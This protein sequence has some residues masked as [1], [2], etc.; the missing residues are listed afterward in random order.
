MKRFINS[1]MFIFCVLFAQA[2]VLE[3][4]EEMPQFPG[5]MRACMQF[6]ARNVKYPASAQEAGKQGKV[7]VSFVVNTDGTI[8]DTQVV[9]SISPDLDKEALRV[10][11]LMPKWQPGKQKGKPVRVKYTMPINFQLSN[12]G[13]KNVQ[14]YRNPEV[15]GGMPTINAFLESMIK[16]PEKAKASGKHG[17]VIVAFVVEEDGSISNIELLN[18][19]D[20]QL[21]K[22]AMR[23]V[24]LMPKWNPAIFEGKPVRSKT[25]IPVKFSLPSSE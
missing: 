5:G 1:L 17:T 9:K 25:S 16:Y 7:L 14:S 8:V 3:V 6:L 20:S 13:V 19:V 15:P 11:G 12:D 22:E 21:D 23:V 2:Q 10:I 18:R 4:V 24:R